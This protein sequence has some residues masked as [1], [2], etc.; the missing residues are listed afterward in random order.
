MRKHFLRALLVLP[1]F[2]LV[3][4]LA[5]SAAMAAD[6]RTGDTVIIA[7]GDVIN[8]DLYVAASDII[9]NG[10]I[11]GDALVVGNNITVDGKING[12]LT[13]IGATIEI[14]GEITHSVRL[15]GNEIDLS[16]S[17]GGDV[18]VAGSNIDLDAAAIIGRD[19]LFASRKIQIDAM[20]DNNI[21]GAGETVNIGDFVGGNV[22]VHDTNLTIAS[23]ATIHGNLRY[24]SDNDA[25]IQSGA[26]ID[27]TTTRME[28]IRREFNWPVIGLWAGIIAYLMTLLTGCLIILLAP[29]R[30]QA[31]ATSIMRQ[32]LLSLGWGA[33]ILFAAPVAIVITLITVIGIPLGLIGM[34]IYG[35]A[36]YL[37]QIA[38]GLFIGYW[39]LGYV[40]KV[41][42]RGGLVGA[43]ALGFTMLTLV[44]LIP[45]I[46]WVIWLLTVLF[47]LGAM[48]LSQR[49]M[50]NL[51][52]TPAPEATS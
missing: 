44:K 24:T 11:N 20:I 8:D 43:F 32:P 46:G 3:L 28:P 30:A 22:E 18:L 35:I 2:L 13:A 27:G 41:N 15:A 38:G 21:M 39:I 29:K 52:L 49:T 10:T 5:P 14:G 37:C 45:Y 31:V 47:G 34:V 19:L 1:V 33:V 50:K 16:G 6:M 7:T 48:A 4:L 42:S 51:L 9:I 25:V 36:I 40:T 26:A 17:I 23:T 12:S